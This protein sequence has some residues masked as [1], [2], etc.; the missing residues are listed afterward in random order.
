M[1]VDAELCCLGC[2]L[3]AYSRFIGSSVIEVDIQPVVLKRTC[4]W[5]VG[6]VS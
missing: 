4:V 2:S 3:L 1:V 6:R 5:C